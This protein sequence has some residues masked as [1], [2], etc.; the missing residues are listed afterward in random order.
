M[1]KKIKYPKKKRNYNEINKAY[2]I[3][4]KS[5]EKSKN[6]LTKK[7]LKLNSDND[8]IMN[9]QIY[10]NPDSFIVNNFD[11]KQE[12]FIMEEK[13]E[14]NLNIPSNN[15]FKFTEKSENNYKL[16]FE[17]LKHLNIKKNRVKEIEIERDGNCYFNT[18][19]I[20]IV[21]IIHLK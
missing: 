2:K 7:K 12:Y 10:L 17:I 11:V 13:L 6:K 15:E 5:E 14:Y 19:Y 3:I 1:K 18:F 4:D 20:N 16:F 8:F 21:L 9:N